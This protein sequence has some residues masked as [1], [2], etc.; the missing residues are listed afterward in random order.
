MRISSKKPRI[1]FASKLPSNA[2]FV[3]RCSSPESLSTDHMRPHEGGNV[4]EFSC[5]VCEYKCTTR[6]QLHRDVR[7]HKFLYY[8]PDCKLFFTSNQNLQEHL[9]NTHPESRHQKILA[10]F[11]TFFYITYKNRK[12]NRLIQENQ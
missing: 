1:F 7:S 10:F 8:C 5:E 2:R 3:Q 12:Q 9:I 4:S 11:I 6:R